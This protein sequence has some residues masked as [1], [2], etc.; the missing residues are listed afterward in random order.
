[1]QATDHMRP[2]DHCDLA[3]FSDQR[4]LVP[5]FFRQGANLLGESQCGE[6]ILKLKEAK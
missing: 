4:G 5:F 1:M 6:I 3:L 2:P